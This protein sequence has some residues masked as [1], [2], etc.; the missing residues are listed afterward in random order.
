MLTPPTSLTTRQV[1][2]MLVFVLH[3]ESCINCHEFCQS[4]ISTPDATN[5]PHPSL[6]IDLWLDY[7]HKNI[8]RQQRSRLSLPD[9][10][11]ETEFFTTSGSTTA[12]TSTHQPPYLW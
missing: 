4:Q 7:A 12:I 11:V 5:V 8:P 2:D 10:F 9:T 6:D 3:I 1:A